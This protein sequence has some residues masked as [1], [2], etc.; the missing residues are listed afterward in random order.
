MDETTGSVTLRALLPNPDR[1]L[2]PG[3]FVRAS[4]GEGERQNGLLLP[5]AAL[6]RTQ[7]GGSSVLLVNQDNK[8]ESRDITVSRT[9][10]NS[11]VIESGLKA[12]ERVVVAGL[13]KVK[14]GAAVQPHEVSADEPVQG[15]E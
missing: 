12:G 13:Q 10:G 4:L 14:A 7:R 5:Q 9:Y 15:K 6:V 8:V 1:L 2:L 3:M 11:W